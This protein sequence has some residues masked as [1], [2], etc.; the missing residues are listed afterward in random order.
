[1]LDGRVFAPRDT[2][3][4]SLACHCSGTSQ[5]YKDQAAEAPA[6]AGV[7]GHVHIP[8]T[9]EHI[10]IP[11]EAL[12]FDEHGQGA[13]HGGCQGVHTEVSTLGGRR[14]LVPGH[15]AAA[16]ETRLGCIVVAVPS[17]SSYAKESMSAVTGDDIPAR[18][19]AP[20]TTY[21]TISPGRRGSPA[22]DA[23]VALS[24]ATMGAELG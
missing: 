20:G 4:A 2:P 10:T 11:E 24:I 14:S 7:W 19:D 23:A 3:C 12:T 21:A 8:T 17:G 5:S 18:R 22:S 16:Q 13:E 6:I 15:K 9:L 1:M